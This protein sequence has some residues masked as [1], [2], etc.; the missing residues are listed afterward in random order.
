MS[1]RLYSLI[2]LDHNYQS[3]EEKTVYT[4]NGKVFWLAYLSVLCNTLDYWSLP[5][6]FF[7]LFLNTEDSKSVSSLLTYLSY[8]KRTHKW[9]LFH[10]LFYLAESDVSL[11][12][13]RRQP[14]QAHEGHQWCRFPT[15]AVDFLQRL[16]IFSQTFCIYSKYPNIRPWLGITSQKPC[17]IRY[18]SCSDHALTPHSNISLSTPPLIKKTVEDK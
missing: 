7:L 18:Y 5:F 10:Y 16:A 6:F 14:Q 13:P 2:Y 11:L 9:F 4:K 3:S 1:K 8:M 15:C 17:P 12:K